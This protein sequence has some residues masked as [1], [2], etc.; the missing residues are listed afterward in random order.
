MA[1]LQSVYHASNIEMPKES[2]FSQQL[3]TRRE[4]HVTVKLEVSVQ[5]SVPD[6]QVQ[7]IHLN[8]PVSDDAH[9]QVGDYVLSAAG[10]V[11]IYFSLLQRVD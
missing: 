8:R 2:K 11:I 9:I 1:A 4:G 5:Q 10:N 7:Q 6:L 3:V